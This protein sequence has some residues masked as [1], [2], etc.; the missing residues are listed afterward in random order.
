MAGIVRRTGWPAG[1]PQPLTNNNNN[2]H[3]SPA[4]QSEIYN[5]NRTIQL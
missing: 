4:K 1:T 2:N 5:M 3:L